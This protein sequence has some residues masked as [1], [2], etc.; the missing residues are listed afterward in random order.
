MV[1]PLLAHHHPA[2]EVWA[3]ILYRSTRVTKISV[4][5]LAATVG[6]IGSMLFV[7]LEIRQNTEAVHGSTIHG[8]ADQSM[9]FNLE[10]SLN[11]E[12]LAVYNR[13]TLDSVPFTELSEM[14]RAQFGWVL[15]TSTR[16]MEN[17][18]RQ[19]QLGIL[20]EN[21]MRQLGASEIWYGSWWFRAWW[22]QA[23]PEKR[24]APDFVAFMERDVLSPSPSSPSAG[25]T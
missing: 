2:L 14:E 9:Q 13:V 19:R 20:D 10:L 3:H 1:R 16:I 7:G 21:A 11:R 8:I 18:F 24:W 12:W 23:N 5:E 4:R 22:D 17:R 6:V 15:T 25:G